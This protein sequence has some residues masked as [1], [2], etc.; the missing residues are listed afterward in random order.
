MFVGDGTHNAADCQAVEV[1]VD[2][3]QAA[4]A[5]RCELRAFSGFDFLGRPVAE[6]SAAAGAVHELDH[7]AQND[8]EYQNAHVVGF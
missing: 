2:E 6:G 3:D 7:D 5:D 4:K 1:V 8:Q